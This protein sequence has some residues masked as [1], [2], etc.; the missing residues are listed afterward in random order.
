[1][2]DNVLT[3]CRHAVDDGIDAIQAGDRSEAIESFQRALDLLHEVADIE[4]RRDELGPLALLL[5]RVGLHDLSLLAAREAV[6]LDEQLNDRN[7]L[8]QDILQCGTAMGRLGDI[9]AAVDAYRHARSL[10]VEDG[11]WANA[12]SATTN[13]AVVVGQDDLDEAID[14]LEESLVFLSREGFPDTEITT[15][16][17]LIQAL[18]AAGRPPERVFEIAFDLFDRFLDDLRPDQRRNS[19]GPLEQAIGRH[20][21]THPDL[22][23]DAWR[24]ARFPMLYG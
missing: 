5:D 21:A 19:V 3:A 6:A 16:I 24:A 8:G 12:A 18:E 2:D 15:R 13:L 17:A 11:H 7:A 10:F 22:D 1:M 9:D 23:P 14:L 20:L 4:T